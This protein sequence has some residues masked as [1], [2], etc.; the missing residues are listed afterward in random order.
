MQ[1]DESDEHPENADSSIDESLEPDSNVTVERDSHP[2]KHL[3]SSLST[4]DGMQI[5]ESD[6]QY[7]NED[8]AIDESL[9]PNSNVIVER[10]LQ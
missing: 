6:G 5:D 1:I 4:E 8:S 10:D 9:E 3:K 2:Q 7:K